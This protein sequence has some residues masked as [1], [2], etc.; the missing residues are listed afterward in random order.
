MSTVYA[1]REYSFRR[2]FRLFLNFLAK[3]LPVSGYTRLKIY[4]CMG[5]N[6]EKGNGRCGIVCFDT[7]HPEDIHIGKGCEIVDGCTILSHFYD[8]VDM[9]AHRH[10]RGKIIIGRNV[11]I[12]TNTIIVKPVTVGDGAI[13][14]AGSVVN[15]D[16]PPY[17]V[18]A[19]VPAKFIKNR[20]SENNFIPLSTEE[21]K[22]KS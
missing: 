12:G 15:K 13:I 18:W 17:Q 6:I 9:T 21:F 2:L 19:G 16:I 14:G 7:I 22:S 5:V 10:Y 11:Y 1:K 3:K 20:Y 8:V 4:R